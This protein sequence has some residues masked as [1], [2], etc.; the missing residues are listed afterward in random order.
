MS[1]T[2]LIAA[3]A[4]ACL[5]LIMVG[6]AEASSTNATNAT[7]RPK[8][9]RSELIRRAQMRKFGG[10]IAR[11]DSLRGRICIVDAQTGFSN[12]IARVA[13][14]FAQLTRFRIEPCSH[15]GKP[16]LG[17]IPALMQAL[18]AEAYVFVTSDGS[19][20]SLLVA[21][22]N[23]WVLVNTANL[24]KEAA[25]EAVLKRRVRCEVARGL[26]YVAGAANSLYAR[27]LMSAVREPRDLDGTTNE[28]PPVDVVS[29][30]QSYL[31]PFGITPFVQTPYS[32][33][34][35]EGWAPAPTNAY[36]QAIWDEM[37][38]EK[39]RGPTNGL[40]IPPPNK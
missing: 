15:A 30:F 18:E 40:Q 23:G 22:E 4:V 26:A 37:K 7:G 1:K 2:R 8:V 27:S 29:R 28:M 32:Q 36:Q 31:K 35:E 16:N 10:F 11:P 14:E 9:K 5:S 6:T 13:K 24:G 17:N 34:V 38:A 19:L 3:S 21:P 12:E 39:E 33:A 25:S 20:P